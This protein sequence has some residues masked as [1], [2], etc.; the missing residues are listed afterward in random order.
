MHKTEVYFTYRP[1]L[2]VPFSDRISV[3]SVET[4]TVDSIICNGATSKKA[5][6]KCQLRAQPSP[7]EVSW[8]RGWF[9]DGWFVDG[10][11]KDEG[12][13]ESWWGKEG[14]VISVSDVP[15][16]QHSLLG[17]DLFELAPWCIWTLGTLIQL[18]NLVHTYFAYPSFILWTLPWPIA[19]SGSDAGG[20][21]YHFPVEERIGRL[22]T[23]SYYT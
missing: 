7:V 15:D 12:S 19:Y 3:P 4:L 9:V 17:H 16:I 6:H 20:A 23:C 21:A 8:L 10:K 5:V 2:W 22:F 11:D 14:M 1:I 13:Q 18:V